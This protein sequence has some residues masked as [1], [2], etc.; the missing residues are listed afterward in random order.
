MT[1]G[2]WGGQERGPRFF[3]GAERR[4]KPDPPLDCFA[5]LAMTI[6]WLLLPGEQDRDLGMAEDVAGGAAEHQL[7]QPALRVG[8][9]EH[10]VA[11]QLGGLAQERLARDL[12]FG[13]NVAYARRDAVT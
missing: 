8:A 6:F 10:Q 11:L 3:F 4:R 1:A 7:A 9:L 13:L 2:V 5:P 12:T